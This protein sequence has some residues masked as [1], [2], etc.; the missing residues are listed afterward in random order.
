MV[1]LKTFQKKQQKGVDNSTP[2]CY[3]IGTVKKGGHK[4]DKF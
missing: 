1:I 2:L 3:N 4:N